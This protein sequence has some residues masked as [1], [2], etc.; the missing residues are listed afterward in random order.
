MKKT[1]CLLCGGMIDISNNPTSCP[2]C[3]NS[4]NYD[5]VT[6]TNKIEL[7]KH[8]ALMYIINNEYNR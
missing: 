2:H 3:Q 5:L 4:I 7:L 8:D 6:K 1:K